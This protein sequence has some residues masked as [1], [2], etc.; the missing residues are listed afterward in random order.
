MNKKMMF[1]VLAAVVVLVLGSM[2][3]AYATSFDG[4]GKTPAAVGVQG[5]AGCPM[6]QGGT[7][8]MGQGAGACQGSGAGCQMQGGNGAGCPMGQGGAC[9]AAQ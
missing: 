5:G 3:V 8:Q 7:C 6:G 9:G 1:V 4:L 2:G